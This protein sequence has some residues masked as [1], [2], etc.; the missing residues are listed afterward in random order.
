MSTLTASKLEF[1]AF[2]FISYD[3]KLPI[4]RV[5]LGGLIFMVL[6][7][8]VSELLALQLTSRYSFSESEINVAAILPVCTV[9]ID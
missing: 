4:F 7:H 3:G 6:G 8:S 9:L 5:N 2:G 1:Q